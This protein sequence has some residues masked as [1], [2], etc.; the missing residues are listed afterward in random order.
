MPK[1]P[2]SDGAPAPIELAIDARSR[3]IGGIAVRR[4]LPSS[5]RRMVGPFIFVD[6]M[7]PTTFAPGEGLDVRPHPHIGLA[8][9]TYL[10]E[11][12]IVHRDSLGS[13]QA[14]RA[15]AVNWMTA[16]RGIV[17]SERTGDELRAAGSRLHGLQLWVAL[18]LEHEEAAPSFHHHAV[19]SIPEVALP[20][21]R[22]RL[23]AGSAYGVV[24]PVA[25]L[26][27]LFYADVAMEAGSELR[28][29]DE[30]A[31]RATYVV[32]GEVACGPDP[33]G[34]GRMLVFTTGAPATLR[35]ASPTRLVLLGGAPLAG[36]RHIDWNFVSSSVDRLREARRNWEE[37]RFPRVPGDEQDFVPY[38]GS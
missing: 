26:S 16:G 34:P 9:V 28:L 3:D 25:V 33:A 19:A 8:T 36:R 22:V 27:P 1:T 13:H 6:H 30:H 15:G 32:E 5:R 18:P 12:E 17:H 23:L 7:G 2:A 10:F 31:E 29:P 20:G 21:V 11:G 37:G 35:A 14:I 38:P 4:L 24:S